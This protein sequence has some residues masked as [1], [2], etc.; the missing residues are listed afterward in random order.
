MTVSTDVVEYLRSRER[1]AY[2]NWLT[3][4]PERVHIYATRWHEALV[5]LDDEV[6]A[7]TRVVLAG[8]RRAAP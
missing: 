8:L 3:S 6:K 4:P 7:R 1:A 2:L 5:A